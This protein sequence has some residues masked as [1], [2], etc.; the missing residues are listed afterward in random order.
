MIGKVN[1]TVGKKQ[2]LESRFELVLRNWQDVPNWISELLLDS[3][4]CGSRSHSILFNRNVCRGF[5]VPDPYYMLGMWEEDNWKLLFTALWR[6]GRTL[7][8]VFHWH[9]D[10]IWVTTSR[11]SSIQMT[12][13]NFE[14]RIRSISHVE[15]MWIAVDREGG[16]WL[17]EFT[18]DGYNSIFHPVHSSLLYATEFWGIVFTAIGIRL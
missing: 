14:G 13:R 11:T 7:L 1:P 2:L 5:P 3:V 18:K 16:R 10:L 15:R 17:I 6:W 8:E 4:L 12:L 9:L